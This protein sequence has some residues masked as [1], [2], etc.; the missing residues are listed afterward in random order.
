MAIFKAIEENTLPTEAA[1]SW[2]RLN[3]DLKLA[4]SPLAIQLLPRRD[5]GPLRGEDHL[6]PQALCTLGSWWATGSSQSATC[7]I[8]PVF[9]E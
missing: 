7:C 9:G 6:H 1:R 2:K 3:H 4:Y 8:A 5:G